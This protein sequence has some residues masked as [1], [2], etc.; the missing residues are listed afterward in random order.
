M[1][2]S[3]NTVEHIAALAR[4][5]LTPEETEIYRGQLRSIID[6]VDKLKEL[7]TKNVPEMQHAGG[8]ANVLRDDET[9]PSDEETRRRI[10]ES[11]P[12]RAGDLLEVQAVFE[13][14]D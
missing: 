9:R 8:L 14:K 1:E 7:N 10:V 4:L 12:R 11:F 3:K 5:R 6:Y 13:D 2:L